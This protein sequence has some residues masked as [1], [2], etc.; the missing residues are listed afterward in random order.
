MQNRIEPRCPYF[1]TCGGCQLQ[2]T[3]YEEQ[4]EMKREAVKGN[5]LKWGL[6]GIP[7]EETLGMED[8][9]FYRNKI[10]F[11]IREQNNRLQMGYFRERTHEVVNVK[12]CYIQDPFLTEI[13]Q[14]ARK[15]F[16]DRELS[17]YNEKTGEGLLR[18]FIGRSGFKTQEILL[19]IVIKGRGLPAGFSVAYEIKKH[20]RLMHR[21]VSRHSDYPRYDKKRKIIGIVQNINTA[22]SEIILGKQNTTLHG[23]PYLREK[24]GDFSFTVKLSSFF[25]VNPVQAVKIY[26]LVE[27][28]AELSGKEIVVDAYA[29]IG[30][31]AFW[32][33]EGAEK[34]IGIEE[35]E[36]AVKDANKNIDAN[37]IRNVVMKFGRIEEVFPRKADVVILNPPRAGCTEHALKAVIRAA[38]NRIIY[39]SC[40]PETL[41]KNLKMLVENKYCV[42]VIQPVD[43]FPQ[44]NHVEAVARLSFK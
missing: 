20:E 7:V 13:A 38:P 12:E 17:A 40:N 30:P 23:R 33:S 34:V 11:P 41:A 26:D 27:D 9:W 42:E 19:G 35:V 24:L 1:G 2:D 32:L 16:E 29:G 36:E 21:N 4:L 3:P 37:K 5:L 44:T 10:Q 15:I 43:M 14:I 39:V 8:P 22:R 6:E 25:Q 31:I 28:Y 18:H